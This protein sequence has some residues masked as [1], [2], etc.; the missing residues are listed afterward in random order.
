MKKI[1]VMR[2]AD[3]AAEGATCKLGETKVELGEEGE[4]TYRAWVN[5]HG[6]RCRCRFWWWNRVGELPGLC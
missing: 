1:H 2:E 5:V 4:R 6:R 3:D